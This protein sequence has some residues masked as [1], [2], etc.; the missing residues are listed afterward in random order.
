MSKKSRENYCCDKQPILN[1]PLD[2]IVVDELHLILRITDI[3]IGN[4]VQ[5]CLDWDKDDDLDHKNGAATGLYLKSLIRV[6]KS[7]GVSFDVWEQRNADGKGSR[8][9]DWTSLLGKD[10]KG[11]PLQCSAV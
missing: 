11:I 10:K 5:E 1:I 4:L 9:H 7:C 8:K 2:H 6:I 3:L